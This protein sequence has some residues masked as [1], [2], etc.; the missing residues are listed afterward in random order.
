VR[1]F[2][3]KGEAFEVGKHEGKP[4]TVEEK[5][6]LRELVKSRACS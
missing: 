2:T 1:I 6:K 3:L 4:W 5:R